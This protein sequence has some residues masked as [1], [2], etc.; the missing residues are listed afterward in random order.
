MSNANGMGPIFT[1]RHPTN[2]ERLV[3]CDIGYDVNVTYGPSGSSYFWNQYSGSC[4][5]IN[6]AGVNDGINADQTYAWVLPMNVPSPLSGFLSNDVNA[7]SI[8]CPQVVI[9]AG[10]ISNVGN[11]SFDYAPTTPGPHLIRYVPKNGDDEG[12]ITYIFVFVGNSDCQPNFCSMVNNGN[13]ESATECGQFLPTSLNCWQAISGTPDV[14]KRFNCQNNFFTTALSTF[15]S[16]PSC[17][18]YDGVGNDNFIGIWA[19]GS[20][21]PSTERAQ[22]Q[23][24]QPLIN[25]QVYEVSFYAKVNNNYSGPTSNKQAILELTVTPNPIAGLAADVQVLASVP[26]ALLLCPLTIVD[27]VDGDYSN[28]IL[29]DGAGYDWHYYTFTLPPFTGNVPYGNLIISYDIWTAGYTTGGYYVFIDDVRINPVSDIQLELPEFSCNGPFVIEDLEQYAEPQG[30]VFSGEGIEEIINGTETTYNFNPSGLTAG[31][32]NVTYTVIDNLGCADV[33]VDVINVG[34][35]CLGATTIT[36]NTTWSGLTTYYCGDITVAAGV[37]LN[38]LDGCNIY[39]SE[40]KGIKLQDGADLLIENSTV[41]VANGCGNFWAGISADMIPGYPITVDK[42]WVTILNSTLSYANTAISLY[43]VNAG[44]APTT[45]W[46]VCSVTNCVFKNNK[47]DFYVIGHYLPSTSYLVQFTNSTFIT[48]EDFPAGFLPW[49]AKSTFKNNNK[50]AAFKNCKYINTVGYWLSQLEL[51]AIDAENVGIFYIGS[52]L[53]EDGFTNSKIQGFTRGIKAANTTYVLSTWI[54]QTD[55]HCWRSVYFRNSGFAKVKG[56]RFFNLP[57]YIFDALNWNIMLDAFVSPIMNT[58]EGGNYSS[59]PYGLYI[60]G[61]TKYYVQDNLFQTT[62]PISGS[63]AP[64]LSHGLIVNNTG[65]WTNKVRRN[66]FTGMHRALKLQGDNTN[67]DKT[68]GSFYSCNTFDANWTDIRELNSYFG[69]PASWGVPHQNGGGGQASLQDPL[70]TFTSNSNHVY[71]DIKNTTTTHKYFRPPLGTEPTTSEVTTGTVILQANNGQSNCSSN[72]GITIFE[73]GDGTCGGGKAEAE[74]AYEATRLWYDALVDGGNTPELTDIV[75]GTTFSDALQT[76]YTLMQKSPALSEEVMIE[77]LNQ[78]N[79]PN[80]L[81]YQILA[82]NPSAAKSDRIVELMDNKP[83]PFDE[84]QKQQVMLGLEL[85]STKENLEDAMSNQLADRSVVLTCLLKDIEDNEAISDKLSAML[86]LLDETKF[87]GDLLLKIDLFAHHGNYPAA[88]ALTNYPSSY[89]RL[90]TQDKIDLMALE[91]ILTI[92]LTLYGVE[93]AQLNASDSQTLR[94]FLHTTSSNAAERALTLLYT[95]SDYTY[96]APILDDQ[97][98]EPR[99]LSYTRSSSHNLLLKIYPNPTNGLVVVECNEQLTKIEVINAMGQTVIQYPCATGS[100]QQFIDLSN[101]P[102][103]I[104]D[105]RLIKE[106]GST[107]HTTAI[108]K[109]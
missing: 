29:L 16:S 27:P 107:L 41:T 5:G 4:N 99:S 35:N 86:A 106:N 69:L 55:F 59:A 79:L 6:V 70:N 52:T 104:Y 85:S 82:S 21:T 48:D 73:G 77:A 91:Q 22:T 60:D 76:Y 105:L 65:D 94:D 92:E 75:T 57:Q 53:D 88:I 7:T 51:T 37:A 61:N 46:A 84:Y 44:Q 23:L 98:A 96:V 45:N 102:S 68:Q 63:W 38:I 33:A 42:N 62:L 20:S 10:E 12:N 17:D 24:S 67:F 3:L 83:I 11:D 58:G 93:N 8:N 78:Y 28:E 103:G 26:A 1:K 66:T 56:N 101:M 2:E 49:Q 100:Q 31:D 80:V 108:I 47:R 43:T 74:A 39:F 87:Y 109:E 30:G 50:P 14:F 18:S 9:G 72:Q 13:F 95:F 71:D 81:L 36:S 34:E 64:L 32:Y 19:N 40:G 25:G 90:S 97:D 54:L 15:N 89:L